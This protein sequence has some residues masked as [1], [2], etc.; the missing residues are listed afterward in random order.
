VDDLSHTTVKEIVNLA[1]M[2][3][4]IAGSTRMYERLGD[5]QAKKIVD[6]CLGMLSEVVT[7]NRGFIIKK[8]GDELMCTFDD[9]QNASQAASEMQVTLK[10]ASAFGTF[11]NEAVRIRVGFHFGCV[12]RDRGDVFGDAVNVAARVVAQAKA[13]Q[14]LTTKESLSLLPQ[15]LHAGT[16]FIDRIAVKGKTKELEIYEVLWDL[17]DLTM[18]PEALRERPRFDQRI[19]VSFRGREVVLGEDRTSLRMGRGEDNDIIVPDNQSSRLHARIELR[20]ERFVLVDQSLNGTYVKIE[21]EEEVCLRRDELALKGSG[22]ISLGRPT[23][24]AKDLVVAFSV[25]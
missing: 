1:I 17:A 22:S 14:I 6:K 24:L 12:I 11:S 16:R 10:Q 9:P 15:E 13:G 2:F 23:D 7:R 3:S 8:I 20:R 4:D 19:R 21:G 18:G 25:D 5:R